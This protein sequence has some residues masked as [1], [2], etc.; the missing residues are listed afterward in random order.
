MEGQKTKEI[1]TAKIL[2]SD[3]KFVISTQTS[4]CSNLPP[5]LSAKSKISLMSLEGTTLISLDNTHVNKNFKAQS[6]DEKRSIKTYKKVAYLNKKKKI[7]LNRDKKKLK[8]LKHNKIRVLT[9]KIKEL[10]KK[11]EVLKEVINTL[12]QSNEE[13]DMIIN[14]LKEDNEEKDMIISEKEENNRKLM[15][16]NQIIDQLICE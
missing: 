15:E 4:P 16:E 5:R 6:D 9:E 14:K 12:N 1:K 10:E 3:S 2:S 11:Y 8:K 7:K 13:N